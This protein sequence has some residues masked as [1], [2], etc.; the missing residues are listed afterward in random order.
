LVV[1]LRLFTRLVISKMAGW[2]D[3][4]IVLAMVSEHSPHHILIH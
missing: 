4:F 1:F 3:A 2:E